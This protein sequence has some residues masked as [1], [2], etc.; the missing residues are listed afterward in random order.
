[1]LEEG[2]GYRVRVRLGVSVWF[3]E[4]ERRAEAEDMG[5]LESFL[6]G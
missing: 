5:N 3:A 1:M 6:A 4:G 2:F